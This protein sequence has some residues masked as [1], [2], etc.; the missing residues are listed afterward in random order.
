VEPVSLLDLVAV[1]VAVAELALD[2]VEQVVLEQHLLLLVVLAVVDQL[3]VV[4]VVV[5]V[6][7]L[8]SK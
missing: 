6:A 2:Q 1:A 4:A 5:M 7:P 3:P 8:R